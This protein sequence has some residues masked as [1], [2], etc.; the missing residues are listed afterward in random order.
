MKKISI[1]CTRKNGFFSNMFELINLLHD[2]ENSKQTDVGIID[3]LNFSINYSNCN[4]SCYDDFFINTVDNDIIINSHN[5]F[6]SNRLDTGFDYKKIGTSDI[7]MNSDKRDRVKNLID[8]Y[9]HLKDNIKEKIEYFVKNNFRP[10]NK[11]LG[12]HIRRTDHTSHGKFVDISVYIDKI[13][14]SKCEKI[15]LMTDDE[16]ILTYM[17]SIFSGRIIYYPDVIRSTN[18]NAIHNQNFDKYK[19]CEDVIKEVYTLSKCDEL[20]ITSSNVSMYA[21]CNNNNI[22]F[23]LID[24]C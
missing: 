15:Y 9:I 8:K 12:V 18:N 7:F 22:K 20:I 17:K 6:Y 3:V 13:N 21:I 14:E 4:K 5:C 16:N 10:E 23:N 24:I 1:N 19:I 2:L 11:I